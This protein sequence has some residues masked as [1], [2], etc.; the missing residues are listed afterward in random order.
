MKINL[1]FNGYCLKLLSNSPEVK[2]VLC[3]YYTTLETKPR[4]KT[5][6]KGRIEW[7][8]LFYILMK[9]TYWDLS[10]NILLIYRTVCTLL[11]NFKM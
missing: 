8:V 4:F 7:R 3:V 10:A 1:L 9:R 2:L 6:H 5:Q 11:E